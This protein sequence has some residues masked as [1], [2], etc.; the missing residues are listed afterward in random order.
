MRAS[1]RR[2]FGLG[3]DTDPRREKSPEAAGHRDLL[4]LRAEECD[5]RNGM[6]VMA[7]KDVQ[8]CGGEKLCRVNPTSG[9]DP[10]DR[11]ELEGVSR[12]ES[13]KL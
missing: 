9:S 2:V 12:Q 8:L 5:V 3:P 11:K 7:S 6:R 10:R 13:E 4:V 1:V